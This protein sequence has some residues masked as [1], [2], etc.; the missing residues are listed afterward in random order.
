MSYGCPD[1]V[2]NVNELEGKPLRYL[3]GGDDSYNGADNEV[4]ELSYDAIAPSRHGIGVKYCNLFNEK[5]SEQTPAEQ[6]EYGPYL[7]SSDTAQEYGEGQIDPDGQGW[8]KNLNE[9]FERAKDQGFEYVELDNPDAYDIDAVLDAINRAENFGLKV[10]AKNPGLVATPD[11]YIEHRN[12]FGI[13]VEK[14]GGTPSTMDTLRRSVEK[15]RLPVWFVAFGTGKDW[16]HRMAADA[17]R[18]VNMGVT[19]STRGEYKNSTD[20]L[21][22]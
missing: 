8:A 11:L 18:Y 15:P 20:V 22:P 5:Y 3:I 19:Y 10:L 13:I 17:T 6:A 21:M 2:Q 1:T 14:G 7:H 9:Q 4:I 16:A 12:V